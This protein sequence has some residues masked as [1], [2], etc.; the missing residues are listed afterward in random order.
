MKTNHKFT[1]ILVIMLT[2]LLVATLINV[3]FNFR[4][5]AINSA[6]D[7]AHLTA[8]MVKD[9]LTAHMLNGTMD[10]RQDYINRITHKDYIERLWIV[11][12]PAIDKQYGKG[13]INELLPENI[14]N[15]SAPHYLGKIYLNKEDILA[16]SDAI[17]DQTKSEL[18]EELS[19][20]GHFSLILKWMARNHL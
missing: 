7:K 11:R 4:A 20:V 1:L 5:H 12:A 2:A 8:S 16:M 15:A 14:A 19:F 13:F 17:Q 3:A 18:M 6:T 9:A 10:K